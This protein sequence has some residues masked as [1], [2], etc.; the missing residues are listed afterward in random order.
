MIKQSSSN[1]QTTIEKLTTNIQKSVIIDLH[2]LQLVLSAM[3]AKGHILLEDV[4]G[5]G[6][7]MLAKALANSLQAEFKRVQ[8]TP[9][10][11]PSDITGSAIYN[12][13][14]H[15]FEFV[16]GPIFANIVL[17]DEI[18]RAS[19]RTQSSLLEAMAEQQ[20]TTD[21]IT[22]QL[23]TPFFLIATQNSIEMAGTF[24]LPEAQIDRFLIMINLG[25]PSYEDEIAILENEE[26]Q[27]SLN[28]VQSII[29]LDEVM[30]IQNA[31]RTVEVAHSVKEYIVQI[32]RATRIHPDITLG[33]SPRSTV[34]LQK[35]AQAYAFIQGRNF[36]IP[37]DIKSITYEVM[38]HRLLTQDRSRESVQQV[39]DSILEKTPI[40]LN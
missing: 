34:A 4:P 11:L 40:P 20:V 21:G 29:S 3:F 38:I 5:T 16:S 27:D 15:T 19:P 9:D 22:R 24:P 6:K 14:D 35:M 28:H 12:Q 8:C 30:Q 25:Y 18:N 2:R 13:H 39:I 33:M 23:P 32:N 1:I 37:D 17:I 10:L 26:H 7:T 36:V 31:V